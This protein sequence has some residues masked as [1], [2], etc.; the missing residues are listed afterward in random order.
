MSLRPR[1]ISVGTNK[2]ILNL[3]HTLWNIYCQNVV[4]TFEALNGLALK[5]MSDLLTWC[6][7]PWLL[8]SAERALLVTPKCGYPHTLEVPAYEL[9]H[10]KSLASFKTR[11]KTF[12]FVKAFEN[13]CVAFISCFYFYLFDFILVTVLLCVHFLFIL[14]LTALSGFIFVCQS[15]L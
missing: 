3:D 9:R 10:T 5:Y 12:L 15:T 4:S 8:R 11:L 13:V 7:P 14:Y 6:V 1:Q 2:V